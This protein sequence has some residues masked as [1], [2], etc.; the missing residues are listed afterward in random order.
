MPIFAKG[1]K[2]FWTSD[3]GLEGVEYAVM[4]AAIVIALVTALIA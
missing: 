3:H 4:T 2:R 1:V